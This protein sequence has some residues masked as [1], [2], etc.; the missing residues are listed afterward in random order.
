MIDYAE[1]KKNKRYVQKSFVEANNQLKIYRKNET[2]FIGDGEKHKLR[3][4]LTDFQGN[5]QVVAFNIIGKKID[6]FSQK[7]PEG[8]LVDCLKTWAKDTFG[9]SVIIPRETLYKNDYIDIKASKSTLYKQIYTVGRA[10]IAMQKKMTLTL[11]IP[12]EMQNLEHL[13]VG[14]IENNKMSYIGG[15]RDGNSLTVKTNDMGAFAIGVDSIAPR[16][17]S[18]NT[19]TTL[20]SSHTLMVGLTDNMS[21]IDSYNCYIDGRWVLFEY[22]YKTAMLKAKI[23]TLDLAKGAHTLTAEVTDACGNKGTLEWNFTLQ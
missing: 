22:D 8:E 1:Y 11:P 15:S 4:E 16:V 3:Y 14:L 9:I 10:E 17:V 23:S 13:F 18:K 6:G 19:R 20:N 5:L 2:I 7:N 12:E 21:G